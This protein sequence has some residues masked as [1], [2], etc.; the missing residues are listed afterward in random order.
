V[1]DPDTRPRAHFRYAGETP[2][3]NAVSL[4]IWCVCARGSPLRAQHL[5]ARTRADESAGE[6]E[7]DEEEDEEDDPEYNYLSVPCAICGG[8]IE[9][10]FLCEGVICHPNVYSTKYAEDA[11]LVCIECAKLDGTGFADHMTEHQLANAVWVCSRCTY[12]PF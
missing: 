9:E 8:V 1:H 12:L 7:E 2:I 3:R 10:M 11:R 6:E 4:Q 5:K